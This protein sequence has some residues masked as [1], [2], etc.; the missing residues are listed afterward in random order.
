M[1][2]T[3]T[4]KIKL[5][6][7][8]IYT[9]E[10]QNF[11]YNLMITDNRTY[12]SRLLNRSG[13]FDSKWEATQSVQ[14]N[15]PE[16]VKKL[17]LRWFIYY[18][19]DKLLINKG[20]SAEGIPL[21]NIILENTRERIPA[22]SWLD[23]DT[24]QPVFIKKQNISHQCTH[25]DG[26]ILI[27]EYIVN[28]IKQNVKSNTANNI[29]MS[30]E[31][32]QAPSPFSMN[33]EADIAGSYAAALLL[34]WKTV[35]T[36]STWDH[37]PKIRDNPSFKKVA[38]HRPL[39]SDTPSKSYYHKYKNHDYYFDVWS[40]IHYGYVG[41]SVGF[42]EGILDKGA[43]Q[44]QSNAGTGDADPI[45]DVTA[46]HIGYALYKRFGKYAEGLTARDVLD[47]LEKAKDSDLP[48]SRQIHWCSHPKNPLRVGK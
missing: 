48:E 14:L 22:K 25:T 17:S 23:K 11:S 39:E 38:V 40:N 44:E 24:N 37:K 43:S 3:F 41:L 32:S 10:Y 2:Y 29:R 5:N 16:D 47:A 28:E 46:I 42:S 21:I 19:N 13:S 4:I 30:I 26:A 20:V 7:E 27:A 33:P 1:A 6:I 18:Q 45:D 34:W 12:P 31:M 36:E 8:N 15:S 9:T 35:K